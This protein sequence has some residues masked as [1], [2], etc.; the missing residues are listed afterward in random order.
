MVAG[1]G[2]RLSDT[3]IFKLSIGKRVVQKELT[4]KG[5]PVYSANVFEPIGYIDKE[6]ITEFN[7]SFIIWG[8]DGDWMVNILPSKFKFYPTDHCGY[9]TVDESVIN[10]RYMAHILE[11]EG[12]IL[13]FSRTYRASLDRI[14]SIQI[15]VPSIDIQNNAMNKVVELER[16]IENLNNSQID[17][18]KEISNVIKNI[19]E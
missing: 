6:L 7:K 15:T 18:K 8:I 16:K 13:R 19:I 14:K 5:I 3:N 12:K 4:N 17:L 11:K 2:Y 9:M 1:G 10:P